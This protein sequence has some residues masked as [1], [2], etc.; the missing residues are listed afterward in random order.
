M[1]LILSVPRQHFARC[2]VE[3]IKQLY[4]MALFER[5]QHVGGKH[6]L[7]CTAAQVVKHFAWFRL[8]RLHDFAERNELD[9]AVRVGF[10]GRF[11]A[12]SLLL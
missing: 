4:A 8:S 10:G 2:F 7:T 5:K 9:L 11:D 3:S 12:P 6:S 1:R